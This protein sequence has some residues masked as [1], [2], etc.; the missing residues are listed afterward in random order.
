MP[1]TVHALDLADIV[2]NVKLH[3]ED[4][5][6]VNIPDIY[7]DMPQYELH[8]NTAG[9]NAPCSFRNLFFFSEKPL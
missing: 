2:C 3:D 1:T 6:S 4:D 5:I 9:L 8:L 7:N